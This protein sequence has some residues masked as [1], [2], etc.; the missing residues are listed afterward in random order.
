MDEHVTQGRTITL[1]PHTPPRDASSSFFRP[2]EQ[3]NSPFYSQ[4]ATGENTESP[5]ATLLETCRF[6]STWPLS[7]NHSQFSICLNCLLRPCVCYLLS[8]KII[9]I[10][11]CYSG[12]FLTFFNPHVKPFFSPSTFCNNLR[13]LLFRM[14]TRF[15]RNCSMLRN[16]I[17]NGYFRIYLYL[18][19]EQLI[20]LATEF[21]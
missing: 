3:R 19:L 1:V 8:G 2:T 13:L 16:Y 20:K 5:S 14:K 6:S 9:S 15:L 4:P 10:P 11:L 12:L 17:N 7:Q 21:F 18:I